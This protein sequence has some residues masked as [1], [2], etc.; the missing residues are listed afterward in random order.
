M[1]ARYTLLLVCALC[2]ATLAHAQP[3]SVLR[4][5]RQLYEANDY[6][7]CLNLL[8]KQPVEQLVPET[9]FILAN[10]HHKMDQL[11]EA[12]FQY[13]LAEQRAFVLPELF[14]NRGICRIALGMIDAAEADLI[15]HLR[16]HPRDARTLYYLGEL[17]YRRLSNNHSLGY[18]ADCLEVDPQNTNAL[19][20]RGGN[21][22]DMGRWEQAGNAFREVLALNPTHAPARRALALVHLQ[23]NNPQEALRLLAELEP[24]D[25][26][27]QAEVLFFQ[28]EAHWALHQKDKA[29]ECWK[30]SAEKGDVDAS[31][32]M[33]NVCERGKTKLRKKNISFGEF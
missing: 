12:L 1:S 27:E 32:N 28:A 11:S 5:A 21:L 24:A 6:E 18:L 23:Q 33:V 2:S 26:Q 19:F 9:H 20:L 14:L 30:L 8:N 15:R 13:D 16:T 3:E 31:K 17:E 4:Q 25:M 22:A 10:C 29:C 7:Q